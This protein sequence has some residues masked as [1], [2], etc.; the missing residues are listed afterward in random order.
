MAPWIAIAARG[1]TVVYIVASPLVHL[2]TTAERA[3]ATLQAHKYE[4]VSIRYG[5]AVTVVLVN[6]FDV[7]CTEMLKV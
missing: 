3:W 4:R 7:Y 1:P 6:D 2:A 5:C